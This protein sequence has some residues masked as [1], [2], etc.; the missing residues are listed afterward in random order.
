MRY[1]YLFA[2]LYTNLHCAAMLP[3]PSAGRFHPTAG[4]ISP[5]EGRFHPGCKPGF[6]P[7]AGRSA[8]PKIKKR[9]YLHQRD[10]FRRGSTLLDRISPLKSYVAGYR[11]AA[12]GHCA[13]ASAGSLPQRCL[14][15]GAAFHRRGSLEQGT[16][17]QI[18]FS[19]FYCH[20]LLR[21]QILGLLSRVSWSSIVR[22]RTFFSRLCSI[23]R[24]VRPER[25]AMVSA[26]TFSRGTNV[27]STSR[28]YFRAK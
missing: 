16:P 13:A 3:S 8:F 6:H 19:V 11:S 28:R 1:R 15:P 12:V 5:P 10:G 24:R 17:P 25:S 20:Y 21:Y 9:T 22:E 4:G 7:S 18:T 26:S 23:I 27:T 14:S 2:G